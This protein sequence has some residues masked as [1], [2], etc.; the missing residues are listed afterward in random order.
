MVDIKENLSGKDQFPILKLPDDE[1]QLCTTCHGWWH[2]N[3]M[4]KHNSGCSIPYQGP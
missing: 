3:E 1:V 4:P 2:N